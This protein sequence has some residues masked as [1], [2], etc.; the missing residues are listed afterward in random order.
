MTVHDSWGPTIAEE[1]FLRIKAAGFASVRLPV[2]WADYAAS[3]ATVY[4][5]AGVPCSREKLGVVRTRGPPAGS[6]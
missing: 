3:D 1:D 5:R 4:D 6:A 2:R